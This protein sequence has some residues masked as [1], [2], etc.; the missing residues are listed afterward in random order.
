MRGIQFIG[1]A[2]AL[3]VCGPVF[4]TATPIT[5]TF[6]F[7]SPS[8][9]TKYN[10]YSEPADAGPTTYAGL[11]GAGDASTVRATGSYF[12][13]VL[14]FGATSGK[15]S[16]NSSVQVSAYA[17]TGYGS[18]SYGGAGGT[19]ENAVVTTYSPGGQNTLAITSRNS[20][21]T[22]NNE[23][24]CSG[25]TSCTTL[26]NAPDYQHA[27][28]NSG[29]F[30]SLLLKFQS[31]VNLSSLT[32]GFPGAGTANNSVSDA[33]LL[34]Y[35]GS[36]DPTTAMLGKTYAQLVSSGNWG[37]VNVLD[38]S[39]STCGAVTDC[40]MVATAAA[41]QYWMIGAFISTIG[42]NAA[43][44]DNVN[45]YIKVRSITTTQVPEPGTVALFGVAGAALV[46]SRRRRERAC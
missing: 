18:G 38:I 32:I 14:T 9:Y 34:Y 17:G 1:A 3:I 37:Y 11:Q 2:V 21:A 27:I 8:S 26:A 4:A 30:E 10:S 29:A 42:N 35:K 45:D 6:T 39:G 43:I 13:N 28:D 12:G 36:G 5:T 23:F 24:T 15:N 40:A 44:S 7:D 33:T 20:S 22:G 16:Y 25:T 46:A 41:A 19:I 31:A